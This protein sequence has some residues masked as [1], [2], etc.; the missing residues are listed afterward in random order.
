MFLFLPIDFENSFFYS[1][2]KRFS[3]KRFATENMYPSFSMALFMIHSKNKTK[4]DMRTSK[5]ATHRYAKIPNPEFVRVGFGW[6]PPPP[7]FLVAGADPAV[8]KGG[9][10]KGP[11]KSLGMESEVETSPTPKFRFLIEFRPLYFATFQK[12][13]PI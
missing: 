7:R 9:G 1:S 4:H 3:Q 2:T 5:L 13:F 10:Q 11:K 8:L 12:R 6:T